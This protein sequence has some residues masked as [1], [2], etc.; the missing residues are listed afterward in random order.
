MACS[1]SP[2]ST[3]SMS[4]TRRETISFVIRPGSFTAMPSA[5]VEAPK[6][7]VVPRSAWYIDGKRIVCTP[8][9]SIEGL[10]AFAAVAMPAM[11][12][13]PPTAMSRRSSC[14]CSRS[15]SRAMVPWPAMTFSSS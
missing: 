6:T 11:R 10:R 13:P 2:S 1:M 5:M 15:I 4:D 8:M 7:G 3:R 12:P 9:T 14:G